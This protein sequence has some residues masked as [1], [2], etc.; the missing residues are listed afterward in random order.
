[1]AQKQLE[2]EKF[3]EIEE[4]IFETQK[5][6]REQQLVKQKLLSQE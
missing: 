4:Q 5:N 6:I 2:K 1:L 3:K